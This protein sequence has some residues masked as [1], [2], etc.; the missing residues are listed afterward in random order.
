MLLAG[1]PAISL[2][3]P[4]GVGKTATAQRRAGTVFA[5]DDPVARDLMLADSGRLDRAARPVLVDEW[6][7]EPVVWD[8]VRR[9]VDRDYSPAQ[10][11]LTG[12]ATPTNA[13]THSGAG[14]IVGL[15]MRPMSLAE[16]GLIP[17]TISLGESG[18]TSGSW[19]T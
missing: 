19:P 18:P 17:A 15:R 9:A 1:L 7:R 16:R 11:L 6:Q 3:G 14:R 2:E 5:M 13:P 4:K 12:S 8:L 10:F